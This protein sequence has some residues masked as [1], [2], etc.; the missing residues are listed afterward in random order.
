LPDAGAVGQVDDVLARAGSVT[1][2]GAAGAARKVGIAWTS[3][4]RGAT[5]TA[6]SMPGAT[7]SVIRLAPWGDRLLA[8]GEGDAGCPHPSV[9]DIWVRSPGGDWAAAPFDPLFCA[10]GTAEVAATGSH[11]VLV[12]TGSGDV[13]YAWSSDDGLHWTDRSEVFAGRAPQGVAVEGPGF[14]A[15]GSG[16][17]VPPWESR[18]QDGTSW[19]APHSIAGLGDVSVIGDPV[20][21][22]GTAAIFATDGAGAV[23]I[24]RADGHGGWTS[25]PC[26]GLH[27]DTVGRIESVSDGLVALGGDDRGPAMWASS[28]GTTWHPLGLPA[29]AVASGGQATLTGVS[30]ADGRA[31]L[32]G[33]IVA[34]SGGPAIG[35]LW[36]GGA[37]L[38]VP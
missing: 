18:S 36:T 20:E 34:A 16:F 5:W 28:D 9:V 15:V 17:S 2:A 12:G 32:V 13:P 19:S 29:E 24:I 22:D 4:D 35:A 25:Q 7:R 14:L 21:F 23:G 10:G 3:L 8:V 1:A 33:Q 6:E 31:Y 26:D 38:L 37:S 27:G 11:A 30:I